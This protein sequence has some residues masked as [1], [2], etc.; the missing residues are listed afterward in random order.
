MSE[1]ANRAYEA[2]PGE[3]GGQPPESAAVLAVQQ[4]VNKFRAYETV[5]DPVTGA[6]EGGAADI[7][8]TTHQVRTAS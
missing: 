8:S 1:H 3:G 4:E 7:I 5:F 6:G 2:F